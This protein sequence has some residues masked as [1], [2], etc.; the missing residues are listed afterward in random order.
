M[1]NQRGGGGGG[2]SCSQLTQ[3]LNC[4]PPRIERFVLQNGVFNFILLFGAEVCTS[5]AVSRFGQMWA[6]AHY[7][8]D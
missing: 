4:H 1:A 7:Y 3:G 5:F 8:T 2:G 6:N